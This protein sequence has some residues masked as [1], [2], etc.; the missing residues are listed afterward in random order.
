MPHSLTKH[1]AVIKKN[2][3]KK[4]YCFTVPIHNMFETTLTAKR[5]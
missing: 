2:E 3:L 5:N 4:K 1:V